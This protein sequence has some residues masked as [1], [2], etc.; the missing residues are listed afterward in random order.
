MPGLCGFEVCKRIKEDERYQNIPIVLV[1]GEISK[2]D[3][4]KGFEA[5]A[6][7]FIEKPFDPMELL[8]RVNMLL[9]MKTPSDNLGSAYA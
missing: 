6:E 7:D 5:G 9:K 3:H 8:T 2:E 4:I 1:T